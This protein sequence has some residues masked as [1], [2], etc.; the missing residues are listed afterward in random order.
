[1][2]VGEAVES[3]I[4]VLRGDLIRGREFLR[5]G[6]PRRSLMAATG[7]FLFEVKLLLTREDASN[8]TGIIR[9]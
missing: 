1:M 5:L 9:S 7:G 4:S 8:N 3:V 6:V 2:F